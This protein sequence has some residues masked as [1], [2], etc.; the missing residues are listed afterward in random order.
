MLV[1]HGSGGTAIPSH[2]SDHPCIDLVNSRFTD[3]LGGE[4]VTDRL[5]SPEW[6]AWFL[7]RHGLT[8]DERRGAPVA[9]LEALRRDLRKILETWARGR[10][11]SRRDGDVLDAWTRGAHLRQRVTVSRGGARL[12]LEAVT[13]NWDWAVATIAASAAGVIADGDRRRLK[14]CSNPGCSWMYYDTTLN[15]SKRYCST[16]PCG[17]LVRVRRF[18][19]ADG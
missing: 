6:Q 12:E 4:C 10:P 1:T 8:P 15:G 13:R 11:L 16:T 19:S 14:V 7:E 18:R 9:R 2:P 3:Y 5:P 17:S